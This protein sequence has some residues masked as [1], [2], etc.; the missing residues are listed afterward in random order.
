M[1]LCSKQ[2][3]T[4]FGTSSYLYWLAQHMD[5][6]WGYKQVAVSRAVLY[7]RR[8][9]G[10]ENECMAAESSGMLQKSIF[11]ENSFLMFSDFP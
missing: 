9:M 11:L 6:G 4:A 5:Y 7:E 2:M 10:S 3:L 1:L 8:G